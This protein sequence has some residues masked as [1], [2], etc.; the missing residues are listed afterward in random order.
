[1]L[2][3]IDDIEKVT[4]ENETFRT[5]VYTGEHSQLTVMKLAPGEDIGLEVHPDHD[6][7]IRIEQGS[8]RVELGSSKDSIDEKHDA[9]ADWAV[10]I[11]AGVW[12]NLVN[13]GDE[14]VK[15]YSIYSPAEH[16]DGTV[17]KTKEEAD[18]AER[19]EHGG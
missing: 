2:G 6:Q 17:H 13:D 18:E 14:D 4:L 3:W 5:V 10:I 15:L 8:A 11:P 7:F 1:M 9:G 12:H 19:A 16:P